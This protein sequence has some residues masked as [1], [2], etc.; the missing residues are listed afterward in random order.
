VTRH[1]NTTSEALGKLF[2]QLG[3]E[4]KGFSSTIYEQELGRFFFTQMLIINRAC[5]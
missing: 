2:K 5:L 3:D 4:L 1:I